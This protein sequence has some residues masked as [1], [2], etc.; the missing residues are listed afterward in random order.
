MTIKEKL[1]EDMKTA[2]KAKEAARLS[3]IRMINSAI[4]N[5]EIDARHPLSDEEVAQVIATAVKQRKESIEQFGAAGRQDL[6]E[7]E[8]AEVVVLMSYMPAQLTE[9]EVKA[10]VKAAIA[11]TGAQAPKDMGAVMKAL[12]P[13]TKGK[14]DGAMVNRLVKEALGG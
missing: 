7:K 5:K 12:M 8:Q 13:K 3:T 1:A 10:L 9:D 4:K 14:A 6:V 11:E 2:M